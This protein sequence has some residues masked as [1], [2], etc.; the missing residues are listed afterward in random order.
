MTLDWSAVNWLAILAA[1][2][3]HMIVG[4]AWFGA[5]SKPWMADA[6]PGMTREQMMASAP[7]SA[8]ASYGGYAFG[9][10]IGLFSAYITTVIVRAAGVA[11]GPALALTAAIWVAF[12]AGRF[13]TTYMFERRPLRLW[14]IDV[15]YPLVSMLVTT[16]IVVLWV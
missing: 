1:G 6:Y 4:A 9:F 15:G 8:W 16:C 14:A 12:T 7:K 13:A 5:F 2:L 10:A 3:A 11:L